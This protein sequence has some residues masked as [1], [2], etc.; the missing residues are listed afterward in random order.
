MTGV[1]RAIYIP[2]FGGNPK[3]RTREKASENQMARPIFRGVGLHR[4]LDRLW[5]PARG[6]AADRGADPSFHPDSCDTQAGCDIDPTSTDSNPGS[7]GGDGCTDS[8]G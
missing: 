2:I 5:R 1:I 7:T 3:E 8:N 6:H 4:N